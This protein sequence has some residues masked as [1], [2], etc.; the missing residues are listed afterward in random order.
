MP[1]LFPSFEQTNT[2]T[3]GSSYRVF[4]LTVESPNH[5]NQAIVQNPADLVASPF[6]WHDV[7]G[8]EGAE[9]TIT[10]GNNAWAQ[11]DRNGDDGIGASPDGGPTLDFTESYDLEDVPSSYLNGSV[12]NIFYWSNVCH[13]IFYRYGFDENSGNFQQNNYGRGGEEGDFIFAD[14]LMPVC[15]SVCMSV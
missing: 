10:R 8:I 13:D 3:D 11:G 1:S 12:I 5:G 6:G 14:S 15:L 2:L 4:P 9:F 7:D